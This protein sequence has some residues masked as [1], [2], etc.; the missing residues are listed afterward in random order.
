M[1][2]YE[3]L[4]KNTYNMDEKGSL[5]GVLRQHKRMYSKQ[6]FHQGLLSAASHDGN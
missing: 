3:V 4:E 6:A 1:D 2:Q 5:I